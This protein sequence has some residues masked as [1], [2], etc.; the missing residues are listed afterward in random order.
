M[1]T[2]PIAVLGNYKDPN[3]LMT[4]ANRIRESGYKDFDIYTPYPVHGLDKAMG[5]KRTILP[6]IAFGGGIFGL[7][8]AISLIWWTGAVHYKLNIGGKP[9][10]AFQFGIPV[11]FELT[12]LLTAI[13][14]F[15]GLWFLCG[16]PKWY[17][18]LQNDEG[19]KSAVDNTFVVSIMA[20]D[21]RFSIEATKKL[22]TELG[23]DD[24]RLIQE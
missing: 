22:M 12:I 8:N 4:A 21:Q 14:T 9:L 18:P 3:L 1:N 2:Q 13:A 23:A 16:L 5:V 7:L 20:T 15:L 17:S 11:M 10:F 19:F 24:V 6:Y